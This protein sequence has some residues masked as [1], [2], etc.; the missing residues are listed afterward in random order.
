MAGLTSCQ[1]ESDDDTNVVEQVIE[2]EQE[3]GLYLALHS[4]ATRSV[5]DEDG[6]NNLYAIYF[7]ND[8]CTGVSSLGYSPTTGLSCLTGYPT[9]TNIQIMFVA[10]AKEVMEAK[11]ASMV[12]KNQSGVRGDLLV[13]GASSIWCVNKPSDNGKHFIPMY[14]ITNELQISA[15]TTTT[16][17]DVR[18]IRD[19]NDVTTDKSKATTYYLIRMLAKIEII[20][21]ETPATGKLK[22]QI[23]N[24]S[25]KYGKTAGYIGYN[26]DCW[27]AGNNW[28]FNPTL[29]GAGVVGADISTISG[30]PTYSSNQQVI[31]FYVFE[32]GVKESGLDNVNSTDNC[33]IV[34]EGYVD[35][36]DKTSRSYMLSIPSLDRKGG[37]VSANKAKPGSILRNH[38]YKYTIE[39]VTNV[40][41]IDAKIK[42][43]DWTDRYFGVEL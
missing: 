32:T 26:P 6:I 5:T 24:V 22:F 40:Y 20:N 39:G 13:T 9:G 3:A 23:N 25:L 11:K 17:T 33:H 16:I 4:S 2:Q 31:E 41:P 37:S 36:D 29:Y 7:K 38:H 18:Y 1:Q 34:L 10:N 19:F 30:I 12:G 43:I 14:A 35:N 21:K 28:V 15:T 42:V 8:K 27:D